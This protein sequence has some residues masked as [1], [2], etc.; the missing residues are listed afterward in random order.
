MDSESGRSRD[1]APR[2]ALS[3]VVAV[4]P[5]LGLPGRARTFSWFLASCSADP[6]YGCGAYGSASS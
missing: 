6:E 3:S 5:E 2:D 4:G 1:G